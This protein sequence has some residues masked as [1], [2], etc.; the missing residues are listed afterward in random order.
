WLGPF[1]ASAILF[2]SPKRTPRRRTRY[3]HSRRSGIHGD[4]FQPF[5][6]AFRRNQ[7]GGAVRRVGRQP[8]RRPAGMMTP[9]ATAVAARVRAPPA[10]ESARVRVKESSGWGW[11]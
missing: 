9:A 2:F 6:P 1:R 4:I 10:M 3:A 8:R 7:D 11:A 5:V